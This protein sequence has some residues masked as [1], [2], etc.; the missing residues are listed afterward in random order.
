M[1]KIIVKKYLKNNILH[2]CNNIALKKLIMDHKYF[3]VITLRRFTF[4]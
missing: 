2:N 4:K 1:K 3:Y